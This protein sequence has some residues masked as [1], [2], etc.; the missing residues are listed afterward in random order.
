MAIVIIEDL[1]VDLVSALRAAAGVR[2][3]EFDDKF[4]TEA[5]DLSDSAE[6]MRLYDGFLKDTMST[7]DTPV[8][9]PTFGEPAA[10]FVSEFVQAEVWNL[11][12]TFELLTDASFAA[13]APELAL[14]NLMTPQARGFSFHRSDIALQAAMSEIASPSRF[15]AACVALAAVPGGNV[16]CDLILQYENCKFTHRLRKY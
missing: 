10:P 11:L 6:G 15:A 7:T 8:V 9:V 3:Y 2:V 12:A 14:V 13:D 4:P 16:I 5:L 1:P